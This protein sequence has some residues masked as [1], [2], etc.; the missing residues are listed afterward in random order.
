MGGREGETAVELPLEAK[1]LEGGGREA[2]L[3]NLDKPGS[4][5]TLPGPPP[6]LPK[7]PLRLAKPSIRVL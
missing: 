2:V 5:G 3:L 7:E 1:S 4:S 6:M